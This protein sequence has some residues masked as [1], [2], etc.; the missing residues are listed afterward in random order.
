MP[1]NWP[2][3]FPFNSTAK[4]ASRIH[5]NSPFRAQNVKIFWGEGTS[6]SLDPASSGEGNTPSSHPTPSAPS[7]PWSSRLRRSTLAPSALVASIFNRNRR[8]WQIVTSYLVLFSFI[9]ALR[10]RFS[11]ICFVL[12]CKLSYMRIMISA[13]VDAICVHWSVS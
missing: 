13:H 9:L 4:I 6:P 8:D 11:P 10:C 12:F 3:Q 5:Q 7:A 1:L 2:N